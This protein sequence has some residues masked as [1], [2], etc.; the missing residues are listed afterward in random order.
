MKIGKYL[1][2]V[3]VAL[4]LVAVSLPLSAQERMLRAAIAAADAGSLDPHRSSASQDVAV[5]N[6]M[7]DA[8]VRFPPGSN[9]PARL[10]PSLAERWESSSDGLVWTFHLRRGVRFHHGYGEL[11]AD[12]VVYSLR[13]AAD[14]RRSS[15][16]SD[17]AE[18]RAIEAVD[19]ND[20]LQL[21]A[22][23]HI[24]LLARGT[25]RRKGT[26]RITLEELVDAGEAM[27]MEMVKQARQCRR[28]A[29]A[30]C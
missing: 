14:S 29:A 8:L 15:F 27:L 2:F 9:D 22:F 20:Q 26:S 23:I 5:F 18:F 25:A 1:A 21:A 7:F 6:W 16:A 24:P 4:V 28:D 30:T 11:D 19:T 17:F 3:G 13:R 12:D 10:E